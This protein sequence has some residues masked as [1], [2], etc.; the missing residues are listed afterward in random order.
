[1]REGERHSR[2]QVDGARRAGLQLRRGKRN[3]VIEPIVA[4]EGARLDAVVSSRQPS[5]E[6][7]AFGRL[8]DAVFFAEYFADHAVADRECDVG[9]A[10]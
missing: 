3:F 4:R 6:V 1:M 10:L 5:L 8:A 9:V 7:T 2:G